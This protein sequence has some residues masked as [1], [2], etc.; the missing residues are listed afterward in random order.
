MSIS[1]GSETD[2]WLRALLAVILAA[3]AFSLF[4]NIGSPLMWNDEG[5][6][7]MFAERILRSGY[8]RVDDGKNVINYSELPDKT[9]AVHGP[10][11]AYVW[12]VWGHF[13]FAV[14]GALPAR[15][16]GDVHAKTALLRIPF[17]VAGLV[18]LILMLKSVLGLAGTARR[19]LGL[20]AAFFF[21]ELL[22]VSII[23]HLREVRYYSLVVLLVGGLLSSYVSHRVSGIMSRRAYLWLTTVLLILL[24]NTF[25]P[26][27][28]SYVLTLGAA[29]ALRFL[30]RRNWKDLLLSSLPMVLS[31]LAVF[32]LLFFFRIFLISRE[33]AAHFARIGMIES[34]RFDWVIHYL[35]HFE[36]LPLVFFVKVVSLG[37]WLVA[38]RKAPAGE[39][40]AWTEGIGRRVAAS[41]FLGLFALVHL[42]LVHR[43]PLP[44]LHNRYYIILQPVLVL[45][46]LLDVLTVLDLT[47]RMRSP[48]FRRGLR[49]VIASACVALFFWHGAPKLEVFRGH[50]YQL[51]HSYRGPVDYSVEYVLGRYSEPEHLVIATNYEECVLMYYLGS[52]V[53]VGY[54]GNN[55]E[56]D[57]LI[58]PD[59]IIPRKRPSPTNRLGILSRFL[60]EGDYRKRVFEV[61]D[62]PV[63]NTPE[64][65]NPHTWHQFRTRKATSESDALV[66]YE[67]RY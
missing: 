37:A 62:Y 23:L 48:S 49:A 27:Y 47:A 39:P 61:A 63:N 50:V 4:K 10:T 24:F 21:F 26:A 32:P 54:A 42:A 30:K 19:R 40:G 11:G 45:I 44:F 22:S 6:T 36:F 57:S 56:E 34:G 5:E 7:A 2:L 28:F 64:I 8:P 65:D 52:R 60:D 35:T 29:E 41:N 59:I 15:W 13:Y 55:I 3:F 51:F 53:T 25:V 18:G 20:A 17:A 16:V 46:L 38:R 31:F 9:V 12:T 14:L 58:P 67:S 1:P 33:A 66:L 43:I